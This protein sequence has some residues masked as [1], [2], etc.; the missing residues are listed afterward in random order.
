MSFWSEIGDVGQN[1]VDGFT[2]LGGAVGDFFTDPLGALEDAF[3]ATLDIMTF[4]A[5][6]YAKDKFREY[7]QGLIPEQTFQD[8]QRT[9]RSATEPKT[10]IYGRARTGGQIVYIEDQ[11]KDNTLLWMCYV[12]AGHEVEEIEAV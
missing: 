2:D 3:N 1:F 11:G 5:F 12:L 9:V 8:R 7:I 6:S 4:G 10:V